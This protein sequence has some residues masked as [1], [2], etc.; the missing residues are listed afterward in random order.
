MNKN[1]WKMFYGFYQEYI[2][3]DT[4]DNINSFVNIN[5]FYKQKNDAN[6]GVGDF[7]HAHA[8]GILK[9]SCLLLFQ[10]YSAVACWLLLSGWPGLGSWEWR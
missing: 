9:Q 6:E 7:A 3:S 10:I 5:V 1:G 4:K 2:V 8:P